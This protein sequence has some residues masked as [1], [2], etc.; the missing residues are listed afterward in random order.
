MRRIACLLLCLAFVACHDDNDDCRPGGPG[1]LCGSITAPVSC[2]GS[3]A[4]VMDGGRPA[5]PATCPGITED[6]CDRLF[7]MDEAPAGCLGYDCLHVV[8]C[9]CDGSACV[10]ERA[11]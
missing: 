4:K 6:P 7:R 5:C 8:L 1:S 9:P 3:F 10:P 11:W 2:D